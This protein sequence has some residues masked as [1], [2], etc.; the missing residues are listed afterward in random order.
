[1]DDCRLVEL[2]ACNTAV[3]RATVALAELPQFFSGA[4]P[5]VIAAL[6]GQGVVPVG[7]PFTWYAGPPTDDV[8]LEAGFV[9][10]RP[11]EPAGTVVPSRLPGGRVV[12]TVHVGPYDT[13]H[14]TY[15]RMRTWMLDHDLIPTMSMWEVYLTDPA[16]DPDQSTWRTEIWWPVS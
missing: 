7:P 16:A 10:P 3:V 12:Q 8:S 2:E 4:F 11:I 13:M 1:M 9:V 6:A 14:A 15:D 5:A